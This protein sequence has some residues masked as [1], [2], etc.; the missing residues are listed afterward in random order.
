MITDSHTN[1]LYLSDC[2]P[3]KQPDFFY[4]FEKVLKE[5][6]IDF[7]LLPNTKDIWAVDY[8]PIQVNK[9][10]FVQFNY[11]PD[12][13]K[14]KKYRKTISD[15]DSI[16]NEIN[17]KTIKSSLIV[18]GGNVIRA[19]DKVIMC[20]KVFRENKSL[21]EKE[22][23]KELK[24]LFEV[25][26]LIFVP[27]DLSDFTGHADGMVRFIDS[28]TVLI[29]DY[30]EMDIEFQLSFRMSLQN[31]GLDWIELPYAPPLDA[32]NDSARGNYMNYLE[33]EQAIIVPVFNLESDVDALK[34][35]H[36][37]F[38]GKTIKTIECN[39]LADEGGILNCISW[40]ILE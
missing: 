14:P 5:C 37:V 15:V 17:L 29:N 28:N 16:C 21:T 35:L 2:L 39:K 38:N 1:H 25:D 7:K 8:M 26:Q 13:L 11:D 34:I 32:T 18:D 36:Q 40:N 33:M 23:I 22:L 20:D 24:K 30:D 19:T 27:W 31:A 6:Q 4:R 10:K 12:Y 9:D 3:S